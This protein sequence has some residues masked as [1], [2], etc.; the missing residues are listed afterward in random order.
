MTQQETGRPKAAPS[1]TIEGAHAAAQRAFFG[2]VQDAERLT[3]YD[4]A[5]EVP[6]VE[7]PGVDHQKIMK[8]PDVVRA[9]VD[10]NKWY[11]GRF[12]AR[13]ILNHS[14]DNPKSILQV[15]YDPD[16]YIPQ[17]Y[18]DVDQMVFVVRG[19]LFQ[20]KREFKAGA[21]YYTPAGVRYSIKAGPEGVSVIE[22][23]RCS[24]SDFDTV[25]V[26]EN[27]ARWV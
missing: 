24:L 20:G 8:V 25:W 23:R 27:P 4:T 13:P 19:S 2:D 22:I 7:F 6:V 5:G 3:F 1:A 17:H 16:A 14:G 15:A 18:H 9:S 21:G 26:E 10:L 12:H 11:Q